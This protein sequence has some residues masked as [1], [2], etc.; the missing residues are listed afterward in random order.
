MTQSEEAYAFEI[1][2]P[3]LERLYEVARGKGV[4]VTED[5]DE[6]E[7]ARFIGQFKGR[8]VTL[9]PKYDSN[10]A[11]YFTL[12]HLYGHMV[13]LVQPGPFSPKAIA[14]A[15]YQGPPREMSA[16]QIQA[17]YEHEWEAAAIGRALIDEA[18]SLDL[19][20][21][22]HY[23]RLF[24]ADFHYLIHLLETGESGVQ[25]FERF[26]RREP[27]PWA[28]VPADKRPLVDLTNARFAGQ[29]RVVIVV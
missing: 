19:R 22:L 16:R 27:L 15:S 8:E 18:G 3:Q 25:V 4:V 9:F 28:P 11:M 24:L 20:S 14:L 23:A 2:R 5:W 17:V 10:L 13:Q 29:E 21:D 12:A 6:P 7:G 26:L 1:E